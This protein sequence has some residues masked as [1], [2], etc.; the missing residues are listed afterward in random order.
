[1]KKLLFALTGIAAILLGSCSQEMGGGVKPAPGGNSISLTVG[2]EDRAGHTVNTRVAASD[3]EKTITSLYL[4]FFEPSADRGGKFV[5]YLEITPIGA[6]GAPHNIDMTGSLL[7]VT[8]AYN[9]LA[10]ANIKGEAGQR[11]LGGMT[12]ESWIQQWTGKT[13]QDVIEQAQ[14]W[15]TDRRVFANGLLMS[16]S[17][18]KDANDFTVDLT[19]M[20]NHIRFDIANNVE[21]SRLTY[22][23]IY[24]AYQ[25]SKIWNDGSSRGALD[26]SDAVSRFEKFYDFEGSALDPLFDRV[27]F[28]VEEIHGHFYVFENQVAMPA[29]ND[30]LTT[31]LVIGLTQYGITSYYRVNIAPKDQPQMLY[32]N[33]AYILTI[34]SVIETGSSSVEA[35]LNDPDAPGLNYVINQWDVAELGTSDQ[36]GSSMLA[37]P[38]KTVNIDLFEGDIAGRVQR[39]LDAHS[40]D[41]TT[42]SSKPASEI[43]PLAIIGT[44]T[45]YLN[46]SETPYE[47]I[48]VRLEGNKLNF[49]QVD[50]APRTPS[51]PPVEG[52]LQSGDRITGSI[53]LGYAGLRITIDVLQTDLVTDFLNVYLPEGGIP[54]FAPFGGI[55]SG[56]I[57]V[58]A[59]G[60]WSARILSESGGFGFAHDGSV[61]ITN[62]PVEEHEF[63]VKTISNNNDNRNAREAFVVVTLD[64]DPLNYSRVVRLTQQQKAE[65]AITPNQ[66]VTFDGTFDGTKGN[67]AA[68]PNNTLS[69]FT[70]LP[71]NTGEPGS[72]TQNEWTYQI[73]V[74]DTA[75]ADIWIPVYVEEGV[76]N[77]N[78]GVK[79]ADLNWFDITTVHDPDI[80]VPNTFTV[81]VNSKNTSGANRRARIVVYLKEAGY[82]GAKAAMFLVQNTSS[83]SL[84]PSTLPAVAKIGGE[85]A[86]VGVVADGTLRWKIESITPN[87]GTSKTP[88]H[89]P[90]EVLVGDEQ[91]ATIDGSEVTVLDGDH[92]VSEKF[93][94][95]FPKI[96]YPNREIPISVTVKIGIVGSSLTSS[97][98]FTQSALTSTGFYPVA[99]QTGGYGNIHGGS[100]NRWFLAGIRGM[101]TV[102]GAVNVNSNFYST[103]TYGMTAAEPWPITNSF[104]TRDALTMVVSD[105]DGAANVGAL[106]NTDSPL[107]KAG[108]MIMDNDGTSA[109]FNTA[110]SNTK[111]Y[112]LLVGGN[113]SGVPAVSTTANLYEDGISTQAFDYPDT[114][115][116]VIV[117]QGTTRAFLVVDPG[118][119]LIFLGESQLFDTAEGAPL[120]SNLM[121]FIRNAAMYGSHFTEL[122]LDGDGA[123]AAP[124]DATYWGANAGIR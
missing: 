83:I 32:R 101:G 61:N 48:K 56:T 55:E 112:Q 21:G 47:G 23:G 92:S 110:A 94:V 111:V 30:R 37:S 104:Q 54:R 124:W 97:V 74:Q 107:R 19:L 70:V 118:N 73:E 40:F 5:D 57:R 10:I 75:N 51:D 26:Y 88:V 50:V 22:V 72:E 84:S 63:G 41:I 13:E 27:P 36:D 25:V 35:A 99:P 4:L 86:E 53:M 29:N 106:N 119:R 6:I 42:V 80:N 16:G 123:L 78:E 91:I 24:N 20:R 46:A 65:I 33:H 98:V 64:K 12:P 60:T 103:T 43:S 2:V 109:Q 95:K 121:I 113:V 34:N 108:F 87:Y 62:K 8:E 96:Y 68:I 17:A 85:S 3:D 122:M 58:E 67:L 28:G 11:Y 102:M 38:Y 31:A 14:A 9:I 82:N 77:A 52:E 76:G 115:V 15:A 69:T 59:S 45:F 100:Y 93:R 1:M 105:Y 39:G 49:Y 7:N 114:A 90:I 81:D 89:H 44:P 66:T 71:G 18:R 116:P 120:A 117:Q 79:R